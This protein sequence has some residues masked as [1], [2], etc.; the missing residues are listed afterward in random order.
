MVFIFQYIIC[1][2]SNA[3]YHP[4][5]SRLLPALQNAAKISMGNKARQLQNS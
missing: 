2:K 4:N 5:I 1:T 3:S